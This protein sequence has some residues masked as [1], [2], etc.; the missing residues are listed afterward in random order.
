MMPFARVLVLGLGVM[1]GS[2]ARALTKLK[3]CQVVGWSP[4]PRERAQA[5]RDGA[6]ASAP[7]Q[8]R[9]AV[10]DADLVVL[11]VPIGPARDLLGELAAVMPAQSTVTDVVSLKAPMAAAVSRAGIG[12]A[13]VGSHPM[14]GSEASGFGASR[15]DLYEGKVVW[16]VGGDAGAERVRAVTSLWRSVG[17]LPRETDA[18]SHDRLMALVSHLPQLVSNALAV[19]LSELGVSHDQLGPGGRGATR[20]AGSNS[21]MWR[22]LL[23]HAPNEL[24]TALREIAGHA[25]RLAELVEQRNVAALADIMDSTKR[26]RSGG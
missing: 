9:D 15:A 11:A 3:A 7:D 23:Q 19:S 6:V 17:A 4:V 12:T 14:A 24:P 21:D 2:L 5:L 20:L 16:V 1:G 8:W 18:D 22:G 26:W 13:W 25:E 10:A